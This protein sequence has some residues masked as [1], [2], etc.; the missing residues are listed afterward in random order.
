[1]EKKSVSIDKQAH[2][3]TVTQPNACDYQELGIRLGL[4]HAYCNTSF[5]FDTA[6]CC[7]LFMTGMC[8]KSR[9][10]RRNNYGILSSN[11]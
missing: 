10:T 7:L 9:R 2:K 4:L 5:S 1:M 6:R 11:Q 8:K 3:D